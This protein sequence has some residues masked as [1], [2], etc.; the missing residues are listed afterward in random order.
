MRIWTLFT[1]LVQSDARDPIFS[2]CKI[3]RKG[4]PKTD[5]NMGMKPE[6]LRR[7]VIGEN[8]RLPADAAEMLSGRFGT[9]TGT[10][11]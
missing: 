10:P 4:A 6:N 5:S 7:L 9:T 1:D 11:A 2:V 3:L 8:E